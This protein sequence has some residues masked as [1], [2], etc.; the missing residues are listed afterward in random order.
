MGAVEHTPAAARNAWLGAIALQ[1]WRAA[2]I[3][4]AADYSGFQ[5]AD[6]LRLVG[7]QVDATAAFL[8]HVAAE[9]VAGAA[10]PGTVRDRLFDGIMRGFDA[11]QAQREAAIALWLARDPGLGL[12]LAARAG[13]SIRRLASAAGAGVTGLRGQLRLAALAAISLRAFDTWRKDES[14]DMTATMAELDRLL[15]KAERAEREG[16]GFDL[17]GLPGLASLTARL[18]FA[19]AGGKQPEPVSS[20]PA[21]QTGD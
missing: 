8:D 19:R 20:D 21:G 10:G 6:I 17:L 3:D 14:P 4:D 15:D 16:P 12:L 1:G 13:P 2:T 7:D 9:A 11:L 18:P 5:P